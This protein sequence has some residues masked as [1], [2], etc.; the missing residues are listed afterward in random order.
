MKQLNSH[1]VNELDD[2]TLKKQ[3]LVGQT[4]QKINT[5]M[6]VAEGLNTQEWDGVQK[7]NILIQ[8]ENKLIDLIEE[9]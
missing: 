7:L 3:M 8:I 5:L 6:D 9:L 2:A 1:I 4:V